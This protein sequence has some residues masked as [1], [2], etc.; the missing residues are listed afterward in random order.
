MTLITDTD[1]R[2]HTGAVSSL[3]GDFAEIGV[4]NGDTFKR[5]VPIATEQNKIAHGFDSF[6]GMD[7]P[8]DLDYGYYPKGKLSGGGIARFRRIMS[9]DRGNHQLHEGFIPRCF[10]DVP[11]TQEYSFALVDVDQYVPTAVAL[12][13][14]W[15]KMVLGGI[16]VMDDYFKN[17]EGLA[18]RAIDE[19]LIT[20]HPLDFQFI[21][22]TGSQLVIKKQHIKDMLLP[23]SITGL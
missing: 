13:W 14:V 16:L 5:L 11:E 20:L 21:E 2:K 18:A 22:Y 12:K 15:E 10:D 6:V 23:K 1:L 19:W 4:L 17:R 9:F 3:D 8:T 7:E